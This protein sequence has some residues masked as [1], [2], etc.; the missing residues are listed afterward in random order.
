MIK[1]KKLVFEIEGDVIFDENGEPVNEGFIY[2]FINFNYILGQSIIRDDYYEIVIECNNILEYYNFNELEINGCGEDYL[3]KTYYEIGSISTEL[4]VLLKESIYWDHF[5]PEYYK[6]I[7]IHNL[8]K[9][10]PG[11][12]TEKSFV[13][14]ANDYASIILFQIATHHGLNIKRLDLSDSNIFDPEMEEFD[15]SSISSTIISPNNYDVDLI[16]YYNRANLMP[17]D[18]FKYLAFFQV[19]ECLFD[20]VYRDQTIQDVKSIINSNWFNSQNSENILDLIKLVEKFSKEQNDKNKIRLVFEKYLKLNMHEEAFLLAYSD[21]SDILIELKLIKDKK[22][23]NDTLKFGN[24]IYDIRCE[25][26]HSNRA[27][28]KRKEANIDE[29]DLLKHIELIKLT[30]KAIIENYTKK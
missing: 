17:N 7:K 23:L 12:C 30:S 27:F 16:N 2:A 15:S 22:E 13:E 5:S 19:I 10:I 1:K 29:E 26:T 20:E 11:S 18:S 4:G 21:I 24:I 3:N 9:I 28:P 25:Y 6:S 14:K 8:N